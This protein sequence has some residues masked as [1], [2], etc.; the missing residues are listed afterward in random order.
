M[1]RVRLKRS[2]RA[3][4][5]VIATLLLVAISVAAAVITYSWVMSMITTQGAQ[6]QTSIK[7]DLVEFR[8][9][10][11]ETTL[12]EDTALYADVQLSRD[13]SLGVDLNV[14]GTP[15][16]YSI[17][18]AGSVIWRDSVIRQG[19]I[20]EG[21]ELKPPTS[22]YVVGQN[23]ETDESGLYD[24]KTLTQ[25]AMLVG[26]ETSPSLLKAGTGA[27]LKAGST[28]R[29]GSLFDFSTYGGTMV[30]DTD[31]IEITVRNTGAIPATIATIY[32]RTPDDKFIRQDWASSNVIPTRGT[33][34]F[35]FGALGPGTA[36]PTLSSALLG[37]QISQGY[38]IRVV[39]DNGFAV[40]GTYSAPPSKS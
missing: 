40:E 37:Y 4:S 32:V 16:R 8:A 9:G 27:K 22:A 38:V 10:T 36:G 18:R 15:G 5:P 31:T 7:V 14:T 1:G 2:I 3:I 11:R 25:D 23:L 17:L 13:L 12:T 29:A 21:T 34:T 28:L 20:W 33:V 35:I 6:A 24:Y 39:T 30:I 26:T 19:S